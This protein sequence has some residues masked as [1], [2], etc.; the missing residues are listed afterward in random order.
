M[1]LKL[2]F[3]KTKI[4]AHIRIASLNIKGRGADKISHQDHKWIKI[5]ELIMLSGRDKIAILAV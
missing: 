3:Y 4:Q 2:A 1:H 5:H